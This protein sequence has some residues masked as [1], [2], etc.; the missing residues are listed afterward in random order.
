MAEANTEGPK[1]WT[2]EVEKTPDQLD[3][4]E[5]VD[6]VIL[7]GAE[8][9]ALNPLVAAVAMGITALKREPSA[10]QI[11]SLTVESRKVT[12]SGLDRQLEELSRKPRIAPNRHAPTAPEYSKEQER[13]MF[14]KEVRRANVASPHRRAKTL[15]TLRK[16]KVAMYKGI[17][18]RMG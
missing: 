1:S 7:K 6:R 18:T 10:D 12:N 16:D 4:R 2:P 13:L 9:K 8:K 14:Q 17:K 5:R 3:L 11:E 15:D